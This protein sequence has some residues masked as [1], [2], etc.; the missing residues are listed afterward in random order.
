MMLWYYIR[1]RLRIEKFL[2]NVFKLY[3]LYI[4][5]FGFRMYVYII[6]KFLDLDGKYF[7]YRI[8]FRDECF[9]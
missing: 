7:S 5:I 3:E 6:V 8:L 9:N 2:E 1:I 4:C